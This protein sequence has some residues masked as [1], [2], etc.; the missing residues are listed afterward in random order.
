MLNTKLYY[1]DPEQNVNLHSKLYI[2]L[3]FQNKDAAGKPLSSGRNPLVM[4][5]DYGQKDVL[6]YLIA[7]GANVN[8]SHAE[9]MLLK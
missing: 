2:Y 4:A 6:E 8:V 5:A 3:N 7:S 1:F 9:T